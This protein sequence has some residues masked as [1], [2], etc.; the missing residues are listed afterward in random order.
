[1]RRMVDST[2]SRNTLTDHALPAM[3]IDHDFL[4]PVFPTNRVVHVELTMRLQMLVSRFCVCESR[5]CT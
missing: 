2:V 4:G 5:S 3:K 1:M